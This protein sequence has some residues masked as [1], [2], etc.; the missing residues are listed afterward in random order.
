MAIPTPS[1][2]RRD[3][4]ALRGEQFDRIVLLH[5]F[6]NQRLRYRQHSGFAMFD[7]KE[8][9]IKVSNNLLTL[10]GER[11]ILHGILDTWIK[12]A[13]VGFGVTLT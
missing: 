6:G 13:P 10:L 11:K 1:F 2:P 8:I 3:I 5:C 12:I 7:H 4:L 9:G